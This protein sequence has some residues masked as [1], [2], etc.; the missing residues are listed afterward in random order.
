MMTIKRYFDHGWGHK[1]KT[2]KTWQERLARTMGQ[3]AN[4]TMGLMILPVT[5]NGVIEKVVT[6]SNDSV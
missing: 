6:K 4:V 5:R 3:L 2:E 1:L